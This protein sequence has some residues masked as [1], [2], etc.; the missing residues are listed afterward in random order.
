MLIHSDWHIHSE[1]SYDAT[2]PLET[3]AERSLEYG[4]RSVGIT[5]HANFNDEKFLG[6][7]DSSVRGV[8]EIQKRYPHMILG[9]ELTPIEK[10]EFDY[11]AKHGALYAKVERCTE[12][13]SVCQ[14]LGILFRARGYL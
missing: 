5:D 1:N 2:L 3:I 9:V 7:L 10:P 14:L 4:F 12:I 11:I 13:A 6:D 8:K